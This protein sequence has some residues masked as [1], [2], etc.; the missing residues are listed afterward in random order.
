MILSIVVLRRAFIWYL[1]INETLK[2]LLRQDV[3]VHCWECETVHTFCDLIKINAW[4][5]QQ[6]RKCN[7]VTI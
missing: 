6:R 3:H 2:V 7:N 1:A 5:S 4:R